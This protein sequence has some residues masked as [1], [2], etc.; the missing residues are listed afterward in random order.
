[1]FL[2]FVA[3]GAHLRLIVDSL[4]ISASSVGRSVRAVAAAIVA[5]FARSQII[6]P[7]GEV[8]TKVKEGF[9]RVAGFPK[10]L[11]CIDG[12][13]MVCS[14]SFRVTSLCASWPGS[15]HDSR[16]WRNSHLCQQFKNGLH[17][18]ILLGESGHPLTR[19]LMTPYLT[20]SKRSEEKFNA[21][22][23]QTRV[24]I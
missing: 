23:Y 22:L 20:P 24:L 8:A 19:H 2:R 15:C 21:S 17:D 12:T 4:G 7:V 3:T 9:K 13:Q 6:F 10:M 16:I 11:G 18:G 5:V 14:S 1:M